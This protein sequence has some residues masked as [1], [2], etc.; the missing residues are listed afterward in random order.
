MVKERL[1]PLRWLDICLAASLLA[2]FFLPWL[3]FLGSQVAAH[4]IRERLRG[5]HRLV[6]VFTRNSQV[7]LDYSLSLFLW[8]VPFT[9]ALVLVLCLLKRDRAWSGLLAGLAAAAAF[10]FL[11]VELKSYPFQRLEEG[12]YIALASG[13]GLILVAVIRVAVVKTKG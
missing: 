2:S 10:L 7:S 9:A 3:S 8:A 11:R 4:E 13:I 5:P 1:R 12:A 6:S